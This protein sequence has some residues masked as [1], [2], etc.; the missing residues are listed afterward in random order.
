[1]PI[2][3]RDRIAVSGTFA[4]A[5]LIRIDDAGIRLRMIVLE[6]AQQGR[7]K[8][9]ADIRVVVHNSFPASGRIG[10]AHPGIWLVTLGMNALV[11]VVKRRGTGLDLD[12]AGP[13]I[14]AWRLVEMAVDDECGH[15]LIRTQAKKRLKKEAHAENPFVL[16]APFRGFAFF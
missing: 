15:G 16:F 14:L 6:P 11:P 13:G 5:L 3:L 8:I 12:D 9:E 4:C 7:S 1:M 10:N 2:S